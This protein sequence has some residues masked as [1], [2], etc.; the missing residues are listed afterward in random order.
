MHKHVQGKP[1]KNI[2]IVHNAMN[3]KKGFFKLFQLFHFKN[4]FLAFNYFSTK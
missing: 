1:E 4:A 3:T 2:Y